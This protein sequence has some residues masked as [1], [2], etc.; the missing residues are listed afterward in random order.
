MGNLEVTWA[1]VCNALEGMSTTTAPKRRRDKILG[2]LIA[3]ARA[4]GDPFSVLRILVPERD[5]DR[6]H[7]QLKETTLAKCLMQALELAP[8]S[9]DGL[10]LQ[11]WKTSAGSLSGEFCL[12]ACQVTQKLSSSFVSKTL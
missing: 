4:C 5:K 9:R 8:D 1:R 11:K 3:D 10:R 12:L 2:S 6:A 7:F